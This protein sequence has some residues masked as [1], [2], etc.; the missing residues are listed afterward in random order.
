[1]RDII[2]E[3]VRTFPAMLAA[4]G[5]IVKFGADDDERLDALENTVN[6]LRTQLREI[7]AHIEAKKQEKVS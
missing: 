6:Q 5:A 3:I 7:A 1:M 2:L 4:F